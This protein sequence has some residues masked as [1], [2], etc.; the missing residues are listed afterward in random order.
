V[1][2]LSGSKLVAVVRRGTAG[3]YSTTWRTTTT[4]KGR[5][6]LRAFVTDVRGRTAEAQRVVRICR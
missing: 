5:R 3:L 1:R 4:P 6:L 2:F